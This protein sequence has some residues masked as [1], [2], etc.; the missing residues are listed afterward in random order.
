[1][2]GVVKT[3][4]VHGLAVWCKGFKTTTRDS[5]SHVL[6]DRMWTVLLSDFVAVLTRISGKLFIQK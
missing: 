5:V 6:N 1:M 4:T 2:R 3:H